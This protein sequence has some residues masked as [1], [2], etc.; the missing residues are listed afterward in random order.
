MPDNEIILDEEAERFFRE[1][2]GIDDD[3]EKRLI[4]RSSFQMEDSLEEEQRVMDE[5]YAT[6]VKMVGLIA[7]FLRD[8]Q[9][10]T[11]LSDDN[12]HF[13]E[14]LSLMNSLAKGSVHGA[15]LLIRYR[16]IPTEPTK[17][18]KTDYQVFFADLAMDTDRVGKIVNRRKDEMGHLTGA[19]EYAFET[20]SDSR[21]SNLYLRFPSETATDL[22]N[23]YV[24]LQIL[25]R[26]E[27]AR[28]TN[29]PIYF[30]GKKEWQSCRIMFNEQNR[31]DLNLTFLAALNDLKPEVVSSLVEKVSKWMNSSPEHYGAGKS[32][33]AFSTLLNLKALQ[34]KLVRP[35]LE[36]NSRQWLIEQ[37]SDQKVSREKILV[38]RLVTDVFG[39]PPQISARMMESIYGE[40]FNTIE[41]LDLGERLDL[42]SDLLAAIA[43]QPDN[44]KIER[45]V[46]SNV[47]MRLDVVN[48]TVFDD[49]FIDGP[50][51]KIKINGKQK[52]LSEKIN[53]KISQLIRFFKARVAARKKMKAM[54]KYSVEFN[55]DDLE[56]LT[57]DF[58]LSVASIKHLIDVLKACFDDQG[59]FR[60]AVFE[61]NIP[62]FARYERKVFEFFLHY[63]KETVTR[64]DQIAFFSS[65]QLLIAEMKQPRKAISIL[66]DDFFRN[67]DDVNLC[68][69]NFIMLANLLL[70]KYNQ[71]LNLD[72]EITPEEVLLVQNGL[73]LDMVKYSMGVL[74]QNRENV[75]TK[76]RS[77][78]QQLISAL[79]VKSSVKD[80]LPVRYLFYLE[81]ELYI[82]MALV[83]GPV[84]L[85]VI[86]SAV[87][88]YGNP[89]S[90]IYSL[91]ESRENILNL[92]QLLKVV[93]RAMGRTGMADDIVLVESIKNTQPRFEAFG[94]SMAFKDHINR[95]MEWV[96]KSRQTMRRNSERL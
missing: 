72:I 44:T 96:E 13:H 7:S 54:V 5:R 40:D 82:F 43:Q 65:L 51:L 24:C 2:G 11:G 90:G 10:L 80:V 83:G 4:P 75:Y 63:L 36:V 18:G 37:N 47:R 79:M 30:N 22:N 35:L 67:P 55:S 59:S 25:S 70:R 71:E 16:G 88:E 57:K 94:T 39:E 28:K 48:D 20:F 62:E 21:I 61:H 46:L 32:V 87:K 49:I 91:P 78:H 60:R 29:S 52:A 9:L 76:I 31:S 15:S 92:L 93:V 77:I 69:R 74:N 95:I 45:E 26:Y 68:D 27:V 85:S 66:L 41:P 53:E 3:L 33:D 23:L 81:R 12:Q 6:L 38:S 19:L 86:R 84:S 50:V 14:S 73:D 8:G 89:D 58:N 64:N 56:T 34:G 17:M 1:L 42:A